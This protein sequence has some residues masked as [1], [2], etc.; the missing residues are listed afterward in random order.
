MIRPKSYQGN[1]LQGIANVACNN[2]LS[3]NN[4][5][6]LV[7]GN[8][9]VGDVSSPQCRLLPA[10]GYMLMRDNAQVNLLGEQST[11]DT[12]TTTTT[13]TDSGNLLRVSEGHFT[14]YA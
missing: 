10:A 9:L 5:N 2:L 6:N 13:L 8:S 1:T 11:A 12:T 7:N 3:N 4:G 14:E